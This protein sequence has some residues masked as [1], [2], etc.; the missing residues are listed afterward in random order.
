MKLWQLT[1]DGDDETHK[2]EFDQIIDWLNVTSDN[3][4]GEQ[5]SVLTFGQ[6]IDFGARD[7]IKKMEK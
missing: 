2:I 1:D 4:N 5:P 7:S 6:K 3:D